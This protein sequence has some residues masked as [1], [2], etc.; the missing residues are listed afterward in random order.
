MDNHPQMTELERSVRSDRAAGRPSMRGPTYSAI[1]S[2]RFGARIYRVATDSLDEARAVRAFVSANRVDMIIAR[3]P[4]TAIDVAQLWES[5]G[6]YLTDTIVY[7]NG[8]TRQFEEQAPEGTRLL[9][10]AD[11]RSLE[12]VAQAGFTDFGGHYHADP[13][14]DDDQATAAYVDW[15][16]R[17]ARDPTFEVW[18]AG[19]TGD[20]TGFLA[21]QRQPDRRGEIV[22]NAVAPDSQRRGIYES[23]VR[24]AG[25]SCRRQGITE[26]VASTQITNVAP[27]KVWAR[28]G[29][30]PRS[31]FYTFHRWT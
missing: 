10:D 29:L 26:L 11:L 31:S 24:A 28:C 27:Q 9:D 3:C 20:V 21:L 14:L 23:L 12:A 15:T 13:R 30:E 1:D 22:L 2:D 19:R 25:A 6:F 16:L 5:E 4:T 8:G 17:C 7:F 18:V